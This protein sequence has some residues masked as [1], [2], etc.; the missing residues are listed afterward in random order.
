M[1]DIKKDIEDHN[2]KVQENEKKKKNSKK[3]KK[4]RKTYF[5]QDDVYDKIYIYLLYIN[6]FYYLIL[7]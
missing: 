2:K 7:Y 5:N 1:E 6:I 4:I 3:V